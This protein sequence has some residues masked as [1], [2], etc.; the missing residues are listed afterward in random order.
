MTRLFS[1]Y[2]PQISS[3]FLEQAAKSVL[4]KFNFVTRQE[5]DTQAQVL[6]KTRAKLEKLEAKLDALED[7]NE[8]NVF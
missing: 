2:Y 6:L 4:E 1:N 3:S 8:K 5:F 7:A